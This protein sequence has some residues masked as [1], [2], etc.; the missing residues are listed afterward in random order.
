MEPRRRDVLV[1]WLVASGVLEN[2]DERDY[3]NFYIVGINEQGDKEVL[4]LK[5]GEIWVE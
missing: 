3:S 5:Y 2:I 1:N 4:Q